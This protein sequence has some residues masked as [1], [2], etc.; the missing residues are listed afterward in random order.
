MT[1]LTS[2]L[3]FG[4]DSKIKKDMEETQASVQNILLVINASQAIAPL[5]AITWVFHYLDLLFLGFAFGEGLVIQIFSSNL[6][7]PFAR[8]ICCGVTVQHDKSVD[9]KALSGKEKVKVKV[10]VNLAINLSGLG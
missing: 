9:L 6:G 8:L 10:R 2:E 4:Y 3:R 5:I 1:K 7:F